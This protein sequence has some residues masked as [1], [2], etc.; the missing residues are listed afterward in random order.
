MI[1][2]ISYSRYFRMP[3]PMLSGNAAIRTLAMLTTACAK[4]DGCVSSEEPK[5]MTAPLSKQINAP[6]KSHFS[7][8]R[9]SS[10]ERRKLATWRPTN[11]SQNTAI[12]GKISSWA[13]VSQA[14]L[15]DCWLTLVRPPPESTWM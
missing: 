11:T 6:D 14:E 9:R 5:V 8:W 4:A 15:P 3:T 7:C 1:R 13:G 12:T 10:E 2:S